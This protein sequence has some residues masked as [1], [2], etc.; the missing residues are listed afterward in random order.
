MVGKK[1]KTPVREKHKTTP[2]ITLYSP[3]EQNTSMPAVL[4]AISQN[5]RDTAVRR[6][7][8][9]RKVLMGLPGRGAREREEAA[10][11][12]SSY[13]CRACAGC[14]M[15]FAITK[16]DPN[17]ETIMKGIRKDKKAFGVRRKGAPLIGGV[18]DVFVPRGK[19][20]CGFLSWEGG[21]ITVWT[22]GDREIRESGGPEFK[23]G[24]YGSRPVACANYPFTWGWLGPGHEPDPRKSG[25]VVL[26]RACRALF[27]LAERGVGHLTE[28]EIRAFSREGQGMASS[29]AEALGEVERRLGEEMENRIFYAENGEPVYP[30]NI[31]SILPVYSF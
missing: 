7:P 9:G 8:S 4:S 31:R 30:L 21:E 29:T 25:M 3:Y 10:K 16:K 5:Y 27:E 28:S 11:L 13:S 14:C 2:K 19:N 20:A 17:F 12:L 18:Y 1:I 24:V 26:D 23:C 22:L 15:G 6:E